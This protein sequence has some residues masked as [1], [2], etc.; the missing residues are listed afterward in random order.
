MAEKPRQA[1]RVPGATSD[2]EVQEAITTVEPAAP[3]TDEAS[4]AA[5]IKEVQDE[6]FVDVGGRRYPCYS[7]F[8]AAAFIDLQRSLAA[9]ANYKG[10]TEKDV[11]T[12]DGLKMLDTFAELIGVLKILVLPEPFEELNQRLTSN[13]S[14]YGAV[15]LDEVLEPVIELTSSYG[16]RPAKKR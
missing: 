11:S 2:R 13:V 10:K 14:P 15:S 9:L 16:L 1:M 8:P 3:S 4:L 7:T 12:G 6:K 5:D